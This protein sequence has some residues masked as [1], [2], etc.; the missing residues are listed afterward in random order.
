MIPNIIYD[1]Y[2]DSFN[3]LVLYVI[4]SLEILNILFFLLMRLFT[5]TAINNCDFKIYQ[6]IY[7]FSNNS[8]HLFF[9]LNMNT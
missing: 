6:I 3:T 5:F 7:V 4:G 8:S 9:H 2:Y 1:I